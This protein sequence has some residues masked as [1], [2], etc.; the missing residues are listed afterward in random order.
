MFM[1]GKKLFLVF[2]LVAPL[3]VGS[4][5][6]VAEDYRGIEEIVVTAE[7]RES[8]VQDTAI[9]ISA[10]NSDLRDQLGI[11]GASDIAN[12]TPGMTYNASPNRIFIRGVG[13]VDNSLGSEPG[14]AI[15]RDGIYTNEAAS[16]SDNTFM[17]ER[18]EVLR[19]P[20]GTLYG[21]NAIG[22]A[23]AI[24]SKRPTDTFKAELRVGAFSNSGKNLGIALSGPVNDQIRYRVAGF[25]E[26]SD[27]WIENLAPNAEDQNN[28]GMTR[29]EIQLEWDVTDNLNWWIRY[30]YSKEDRNNSGGGSLDPY[31][32]TSP[33]APTGDFN[34]DFQVLAPNSGLGYTGPDPQVG[35]VNKNVAGYIKTP[36]FNSFSHLTYDTD[37]WQFKYIAGHTEYEWDYLDD[38][39]GTSRTDL[40]YNEIISQHEKYQQHELQAV[41]KFGGKYEYI[42]GLFYYEDQL[43]Q[44]YRLQ[45]LM[46][47]VLATPVTMDFGF[48]NPAC[49]GC[50]LDAPP[51]PDKYFYDQEGALDSKSYA[52]YGQFDFYPNEQ[53]H[54]MLGLRYSKDDKTGYEKQRIVFDGQGTYAFLAN[55]WTAYTGFPMTWLNVNTPTPGSQS[56]VAW[57]FTGQYTEATH[58]DSW[59][60]VTYSIGLDYRPAESTMLWAKYATGYK[61]GGFR[62]GSLQAN[63][64]VNEE[65]LKS[66]EVGAKMQP[67][68]NLTFNASAYLYN[69]EDMQVP[70]A[71]IING[72]NNT[73][74]QNLEDADQLG[75][76]LDAHWLVTDSL[77]LIATYTY[78]DTEIK[79]FGGNG[80]IDS[81]DICSVMAGPGC[82]PED[83]TGSQLSGNRL[84]LAPEN[85]FTANIMYDWYLSQGELTFALSYVNQSEAFSSIFNRPDTKIPA[86]E[87]VDLRLTY[88]GAD[89]GLRVSGYIRNATDEWVFESVSRSGW[90][91][92]NTRGGSLRPPRVVGLEVNCEF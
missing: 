58:V 44:P 21:R 72:V 41:S 77:W 89:N 31:N 34:L 86:W 55:N 52:G 70:V 20:Q 1:S 48:A 7:K 84:L 5:P 80:A 79:R 45:A 65:I 43:W 12:F 62:L 2:G 17:V 63:Q 54:F 46:N 68:G 40:Q 8:S 88:R 27:G 53:F 14:I 42:F 61:A 73:F 92:N 6:V 69:Y 35:Q 39:D 25:Y 4:L 91:F 36:N 78:M 67:R 29:G 90:Y 37:S 59:S 82:S 32:T 47:P 10:F 19:G 83:M 30:H 76:E 49:P 23:A 85:K 16:V 3:S 66:F 75:I 22:G 28:L 71:A 15:Y 9:S 57:D 24:Y 51:N 13:R 33:G 50:I 74:F 38:Y 81:S 11:Q 60:E 56:R 18:I 64:G 26:D 87:T